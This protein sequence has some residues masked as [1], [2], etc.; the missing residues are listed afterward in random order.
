MIIKVSKY[1]VILVLLI[2]A[3]IP[4]LGQNT[5][6]FHK[7]L[8]QSTLLNPVFTSS[9]NYFGLPVIS[10]VFFNYDNTAFSYNQLFPRSTN[11]VRVPDFNYLA[12]RMHNL[13]LISTEVNTNLLSLGM[14]YKDYY[15]NFNIAEKTGL[16]ATFPGELADL[17][18]AGNTQYVGETFE[19]TRLGIR[20]SYYREYSLSATTWLNDDWKAGLRPKLLFGKLNLNTRN[21]KLQL[22]TENENFDLDI[23]A[24]YDAYSSLPL[25]LQKDSDGNISNVSLGT[26]NYLSL[27]MNGQN[28]GVAFDAGVLHD[29]SENINFYGSMVDLGFIRWRSNLNSIEVDQSIAYT[30]V[31]Q[32]EIDDGYNVENIVDSLENS[33]QTETSQK[34]YTTLLPVKLYAGLTYSLNSNTDLGFLTRSLYFKRRIYPA[35]TISY[36]TEL[37]DFLSVTASYSYR[38]YAFD[39]IGAGISLQ[40]KSVQFYLIT[41]NILA[42]SPL[43]VRNIN[44]RFGINLFFNCGTSSSTN[45]RPAVDSHKG[46]FWIRKE[47]KQKEIKK[48]LK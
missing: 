39:N 2:S 27:L 28:P 4:S 48:G 45:H 29:Y 25:E 10:S 37:F 31:T 22:Y 26:I 46:C 24:S 16:W 32:E 21:E 11:G 6:Y 44:F 30:G 42:I 15:F 33:W 43:N 13:D 38:D 7:E 40:N 20:F 18:W 23:S 8:P 5:M 17:A 35:F 14:W 19:A 9:C 41:D 36:N 34:P 3:N 1:F 12:D 47:Q